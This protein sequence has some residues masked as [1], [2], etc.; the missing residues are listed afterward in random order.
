LIGLGGKKLTSNKVKKILNPF[1]NRD[2]IEAARDEV[3]EK[4]ER[5]YENF[6]K[7][8]IIEFPQWLYGPPKGNLFRV[9]VEDCHVLEIQLILNLTLQELPC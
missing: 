3:L 2:F 4:A 7:T 1:P 5:D 6:K 8:N 9:E